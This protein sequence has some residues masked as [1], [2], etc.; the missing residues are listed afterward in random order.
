MKEWAKV[1]IFSLGFC[2]FLVYI[3]LLFLSCKF[4]TFCGM[5]IAFTLNINI[6]YLNL[7]Y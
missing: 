6:F 2:E 3:N 1:D 5:K 7:F 4:N